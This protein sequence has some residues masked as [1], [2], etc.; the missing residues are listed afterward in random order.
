MVEVVKASFLN[1]H[2]GTG[3]VIQSKNNHHANSNIHLVAFDGSLKMDPWK[4]DRESCGSIPNY[5]VC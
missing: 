1:C 5:F 2:S 4:I 3:K